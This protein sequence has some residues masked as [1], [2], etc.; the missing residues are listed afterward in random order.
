MK[1]GV[2]S[3]VKKQ[4]KPQPEAQSQLQATGI[5][6]GII[7]TGVDSLIE[8]INKKKKISLRDAAKLIKYS[9]EVV[10]DWA[11]ILEEEGLI[12]MEYTFTN[13]FLISAEAVKKK[14]QE[15]KGKELRSTVITKA[16]SKERED[17]EKAKNKK[18]KLKGVVLDNDIEVEQKKIG[19]KEF[20]FSVEQKVEPEAHQLQKQ[21]AP[22]AAA[23]NTEDE[24]KQEKKSLFS[25]LFGKKDE[26][27]GMLDSLASELK[28]ELEKVKQEEAQIKKE[29][30]ELKKQVESLT[31][32][33]KQA[34]SDEAKVKKELE[35]LKSKEKSD[36]KNLK[37]GKGVAKVPVFNLLRNITNSNAGRKFRF[38][39]TE[40]EKVDKALLHKI[41]EVEGVDSTHLKNLDSSM[42]AELKKI[43]DYLVSLRELQKHQQNQLRSLQK[44][45]QQLSS[46]DSEVMKDFEDLK[47]KKVSHTKFTLFQMKNTADKHLK[48]KVQQLSQ[49][50]SQLEK[51][52]EEQEDEI[53]RLHKKD[54]QLTKKDYE[55]FNSIDALNKKKVSHTKFALFHFKN[56]ADRQVKEKIGE[57]NDRLESLNAAKKMLEKKYENDINTL[58]K[59]LV[60]VKSQGV[61]LEEKYTKAA[62]GKTLYQQIKHDFAK[63]RNERL[64]E[65]MLAMRK[66]EREK[67]KSELE[68]KKL[69]KQ[70]VLQEKVRMKAELPEHHVVVKAPVLLPHINKMLRQRKSAIVYPKGGEFSPIDLNKI[71]QKHDKTRKN[72][73]KELSYDPDVKRREFAKVLKSLFTK[74]KKLPVTNFKSFKDMEGDTD[75]ALWQKHLVD[76]GLS[77]TKIKALLNRRKKLMIKLKQLQYSS[78]DVRQE[79]K[80]VEAELNK[81]N[82]MI[83]R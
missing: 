35:V 2:K 30:G 18:E 23:Q 76:E 74:S 34:V 57:F 8:V 45:D 20:T 11:G 80:Q 46:V 82:G 67:N 73:L 33:T 63:R 29:D 39:R 9:P 68:K 52:N 21:E 17:E 47:N 5:S 53:L 66:L 55:F 37:I 81:I 65:K 1:K 4:A 51:V 61:M 64:N 24:P 49:A 70:K 54:R 58:K 69:L 22:Q 38:L 19:K 31:K 26:P 41:D 42:H 27:K 40:L 25:K 79:K 59:Q 48:S 75:R 36:M 43:N 3:R 62:R 50:V 77:R 10:E 28:N 6:D 83:K 32:Q 13:T 71:F 56:T 12:R 78:G 7:H 72:I 60:N 16:L 15:Q 14:E 44:K